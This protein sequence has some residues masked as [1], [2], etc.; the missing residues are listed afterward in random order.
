[1]SQ[2]AS[3]LRSLKMLCFSRQVVKEG[4]R[5]FAVSFVV[6]CTS[7]VMNSSMRNERSA[8]QWTCSHSKPNLHGGEW[9]ACWRRSALAWKHWTLVTVLCSHLTQECS[10]DGGRW[11]HC[12]GSAPSGIFCRW[13]TG[14]FR[15]LSSLLSVFW[16]EHQL[17]LRRCSGPRPPCSH[18]LAPPPQSSTQE[19]CARCVAAAEQQPVRAG[20]FILTV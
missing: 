9:E 19:A 5:F 1:M 15:S 18:P 4:C 6:S 17:T 8:M 10:V 11:Q 14:T 16:S 2:R 7:D 13:N 12:V 20:L 3:L